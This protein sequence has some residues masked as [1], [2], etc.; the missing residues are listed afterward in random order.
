MGNAAKQVWNELR[1]YGKIGSR[2]T[3]L[4][5]KRPSMSSAQITPYEAYSLLA[6]GDQV[7][8]TH[9]IKIG[10]KK[11]ETVTTGTVERMDR[12]RHGLHFRRNHDDKVFSDIL[13]L[14]RADGEQTTITVDEYTRIEKI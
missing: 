14:R 1:T 8:I 9:E 4:L 10:L 12:R 7:K 6:P 2:F 5:A 3:L 13:I 11:W